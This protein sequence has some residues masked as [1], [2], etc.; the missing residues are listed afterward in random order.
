M[1]R[2]ARVVETCDSWNHFTKKR[3][4][5]E[6]D[7]DDNW[8]SFGER[9]GKIVQVIEEEHQANGTY[10][11][12]LACGHTRF[13]NKHTLRVQGR[14]PD[15]KRLLPHQMEVVEFWEKS[16][17]SRILIGDPTGSGKTWSSGF[18][19]REHPEMGPFLLIVPPNDKY[20]WADEELPEILGHNSE[21]LLDKLE[22]RRDWSIFVYTKGKIPLHTKVCIVPSTR[23]DRAEFKEALK[24]WIPRTIIVDEVHQYK[25]IKNSNRGKALQEIV[26]TIKPE[27]VLLM[28]A[29]PIMNRISEYFPILNIL[30]PTKFS[31]PGIL[32][33]RCYWIGSKATALKPQ[34]KDWWKYETE[35]IIIKRD[36]EELGI[37]K[38]PIEVNNLW[39]NKD[40]YQFNDQFKKEYENLLNELENALKEKS[41]T[42]RCVIGIIAQIREITGRFKIQ[43]ILEY[44]DQWL[45]LTPA[46]AKI[47]IGVHH[48]IV[49]QLL[50]QVLAP[51]GALSMSDEDPEEKDRIEREFRDNPERRVLICSVTSAG[52]GRNFQFC[53]NA[54]LGERQ[55]NPAREKQFFG[56][57]QRIVRN[58][59]GS[60]KMHFTPE[61]KV[62]ID[63]FN[64]REG[65]DEFMDPTVALK[66]D[67]TDSIED[68]DFQ[69]DVNIMIDLAYKIVAA[70]HKYIG[71]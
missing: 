55:W 33:S 25:D 56:R 17:N 38:P 30:D 5:A 31:S 2:L 51:Y 64:M 21:D 12:K 26:Q 20:R 58:P 60:I 57:F 4:Q 10:W 61:D 34:Y 32:E 9:C 46:P 53:K 41:V 8:Y 42:A 62:V 39:V 35:S 63:V 11:Q 54:I 7:G 24:F 23:I 66:E 37:P 43:P 13:I 29:T 45:Q 40:D 65:F 28:S 14:S 71:V 6:L 27:G 70:R 16:P 22:A 59:D 44:V 68:E 19:M 69:P 47:C 36:D 48:K 1:K 67:I 50:T 15:F 18:A 49:R 3:T 52:Q